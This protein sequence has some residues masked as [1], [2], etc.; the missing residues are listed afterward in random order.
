MPKRLR[1]WRSC[2]DFRS[3]RWIGRARIA[4]R[5]ETLKEDAKHHSLREIAVLRRAI[6]ALGGRLGLDELVFYLTF[7]ELAALRVDSAGELAALAAERKR[8]AGALSKLSH[9]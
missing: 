2:A 5:F 1:T 3:P 6:L 9:L 4:A 7:E 8:R